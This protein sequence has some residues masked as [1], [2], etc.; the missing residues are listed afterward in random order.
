[1]MEK[2]LVTGASGLVGSNLCHRLSGLGYE[3]VGL[4][5]EQSNLL[6]LAGFPGRIINGDI[7]DESALVKS[8]GGI[9]YV[10]HTAGLVSFDNRRRDEL[11]SVNAHGV[12]NMVNAALKAGVKRLV[13]TSSIAAIGIPAQGDT[14]DEEV[15]Y[16]K[17]RH[18]VAY[19]D[20]K[21]YGEVE[22]R[23]GVE[24]GLDAVIVNPGSIMGQRDVHFHSGILLKVLKKLR[25]SPY[26]SGGMCVA[27]V[28]DV[29]EGEIAAL[30]SGRNGERYILGSENISFKELF[31]QISQVVGIS[32]RSL[33]VPQWAARAAATSLEIISAVTGRPPILT[34]AHVVSA[35]LPHYF[36]SE[37][38]IHELGYQPHPIR[39]AI[40]KSY[41]WYIENGL[42]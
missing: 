24:R 14:A 33:R 9:D 25:F 6:A 23:K 3:V 31:I 17:F 32:D 21:H 27:G 29:V 11:F 37:K 28:D 41:E 12:R 30:I 20:S 22:L 36:S 40:R 2:V 8:M 26:L 19:G 4:V 13:H 34:K 35:T 10:F 39:E 7:L 16:N 1:M 15:E 38:A 42:I 18:N 5:R